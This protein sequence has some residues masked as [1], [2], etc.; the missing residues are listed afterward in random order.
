MVFLK[1]MIGISFFLYAMSVLE[2]CCFRL[3]KGQAKTILGTLTDGTYKAVLGGMAATLLLQSSSVVSVLLVAL[4][5]G[6]LLGLSQA[7]GVLAG[8]NVA[9]T[10]TAWMVAWMEEG[11]LSESAANADKILQVIAAAAAIGVCMTLKP[12]KGKK[13]D[14]QRMSG[15]ILMAFAVMLYGL[16]LMCDTTAV[17]T[18][19][20][21]VRGMIESLMG[22]PLP[23]FLAGVIS[24]AVLQSSSATIAVLQGL[25]IVHPLTYRMV[26]PMLVGQ[27]LGTCATTV[28]AAAG[29]RKKGKE[30]ARMN[31]A[32][33]LYGILPFFI[34]YTLCSHVFLEGWM[35]NNASAMGIA[36][37]H[38]CYNLF[39][40]MLVYPVLY[41]RYKNVDF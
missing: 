22:H 13:G 20:P 28:L 4:T 31:L 38:T 5:G 24:T 16:E 29:S 3:A 34:L 19:Q 1:W 25:A 36:A 6:N 33:N 26:I 41:H 14:K 12:G 8:A 10:A 21:F 9:T 18:G 17:L 30:V 11:V 15:T 35:G 37:F 27:N 23:A 32:Y 7:A 39:T 40:V 2:Q